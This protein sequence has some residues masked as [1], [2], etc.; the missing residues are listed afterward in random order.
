MPP[1]ANDAA[2]TGRTGRA[3]PVTFLA[4]YPVALWGFLCAAQAATELLDGAASALA[5]TGA[6]LA[7]ALVV[8]LF[9]RVVRGQ[10]GSGRAAVS[11]P[12]AW[13]GFTVWL[14]ACTVLNVVAAITLAGT[15]FAPPRTGG[16]LLTFLLVA[17]TAPA[18]G[19]WM[20]ARI[21]RREQAARGETREAW[22]PNWT[23]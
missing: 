15:G 17:V 11:D 16:T 22:R 12:W 5:M 3:A 23:R 19:Q 10:G 2:G 18:L 6:V 7:F 14:G 8:V 13:A 4:W 1:T 20:A 9:V 21:A